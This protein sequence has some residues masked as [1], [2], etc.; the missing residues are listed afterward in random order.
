ML[1]D[2]GGITVL[3]DPVAGAPTVHRAALE[4]AALAHPGA[5]V[6]IIAAGGVELA[7][8][9]YG[10]AAAVADPPAWRLETP[11]PAPRRVAL[12]DRDGTVIEDRHYLADPAG[13]TLLPGAV[14]GL[15]SLVQ[16]GVLPVILTNQSGIGRGLVRPEQLEAIHRRLEEVLAEAG[17][18]LGGIFSCPH[19]P[20]AGCACRKPSAGLARRAAAELGFEIADAVVVGDKSSDLELG[21]RLGIPAVLVGTGAGMDTLRSRAVAADYLVDDLTSLAALLV[22]PAGLPV[23]VPAARG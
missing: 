4:A 19:L 17:I 9:V 10:P 16:H 7:R 13:V 2:A 18:I 15:R 8:A 1:S 23:P 6:A 11:V 3:V 12:L 14:A 20:E 5:V 21:H 22:H